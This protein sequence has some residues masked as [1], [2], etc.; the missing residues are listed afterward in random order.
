VPVTAADLYVPLTG[1]ID[2]GEERARLQRELDRAHQ[3]STRARGKLSNEGFAN[4]APREV[5]QAERDKLSE[6]EAATRRIVAQ[7]ETLSSG[8]EDGKGSG[9]G[10]DEA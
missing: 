2:L 4:R 6:W 9:R 10:R 8:S 7:L 1:L 5:V 3:E